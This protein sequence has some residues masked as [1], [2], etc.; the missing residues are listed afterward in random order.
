MSPKVSYQ[1]LRDYC[2]DCGKFEQIGVAFFRNEIPTYHS[3]RNC[4]QD[5]FDRVS[6][7]QID[8]WLKTG[9]VA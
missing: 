9:K 8:D 7:Q 2:D 4:N 5:L 3:C 6:R 1:I